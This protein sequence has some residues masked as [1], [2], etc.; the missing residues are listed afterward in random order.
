MGQ[1]PLCCQV[2]LSACF[3]HASITQGN[4][5]G[6]RQEWHIVPA[7]RQQSFKPFLDITGLLSCH[8]EIWAQPKTPS[9]WV[10]WRCKVSCMDT[11]WFATTCKYM[12]LLGQRCLL[13]QT[14]KSLM[15][16][17]QWSGR[18]ENEGTQPC[19][20]GLVEGSH[21]LVPPRKFPLQRSQNTIRQHGLSQKFSPRGKGGCQAAVT[22]W[23]LQLRPM[24]DG[25]PLREHAQL[26]LVH[27]E[28]KGDT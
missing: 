25:W 18:W 14:A 11:Q 23:L 24:P 4:I 15:S 13:T 17:V 28:E 8:Q 7:T 12:W 5:L 19:T 6:P 22:C 26:Q 9:R 2:T 16:T 27:K 21:F 10:W 1:A 20:V 3:L